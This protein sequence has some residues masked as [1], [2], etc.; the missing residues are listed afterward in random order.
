MRG[1]PRRYRGACCGRRRPT[2]EKGCP[3]R[4]RR[5]SPYEDYQDNPY[6]DRPLL[7]PSRL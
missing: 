1:Y 6:Q 3:R 7:Y 2:M 5:T 4:G